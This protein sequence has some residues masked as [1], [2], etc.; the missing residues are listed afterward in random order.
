MWRIPASRKASRSRRP[1]K[2][3][4]ARVTRIL[5]KSVLITFAPGRRFAPLPDLLL[6]AAS[7]ARPERCGSPA[8]RIAVSWD[9][10][11]I[12]CSLIFF[13]SCLLGVAEAGYPRVP[14]RVAAMELKRW[15][16]R[17][18]RLCRAPGLRCTTEVSR[19]VGPRSACF[20]RCSL[21]WTVA[22]DRAR[23]PY[24][25]LNGVAALAAA[26]KCRGGSPH[27]RVG[28]LLPRCIA[29]T[30]SASRAA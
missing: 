2:I 15:T 21:Q 8:L 14:P 24:R 25:G 6:L 12:F 29:R 5:H 27:E 13:C 11:V 28:R 3:S 17:R 7:V 9:S 1:K 20:F 10:P 23:T 16:N 18:A 30:S 4:L 19:A 26:L 22:G